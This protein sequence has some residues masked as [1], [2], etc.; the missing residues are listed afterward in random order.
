MASVLCVSQKEVTANQ[1]SEARGHLAMPKEVKSLRIMGENCGSHGNSC[2]FQ[3]D[4]TMS[5]LQSKEVARRVWSMGVRCPHFLQSSPS[6]DYVE[7]K[8]TQG[9]RQT[10]G[11]LGT[12][13]V[14]SFVNVTQESLEKKEFQ[15]RISPT[16]LAWGGGVCL[17]DD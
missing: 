2:V 15:L 17:I 7:N 13:P 16:E 10:Q 12:Y 4:V 3:P 14:Q 8:M 9:K 1:G 6:A 5:T 11:L